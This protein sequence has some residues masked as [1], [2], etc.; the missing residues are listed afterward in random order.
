MLQSFSILFLLSV[1]LNYL[2]RKYLKLSSTIGL[3]I[4]GLIL[5]VSIGLLKPVFPG[6]Y[7]FFCN[8]VENT[9]FENLLFDGMLSF[10]LFAGAI[11]VNI[12][13]LNKEKWSVLL[14]ASLGVLISTFVVG[15]IVFF[16][17]QLFNIQLPFIYALLFG[18]LIS[19]TDPIAVIAILKE[20]GVSKSLEMKIEGESLFNDGVGV[21]V[22]SG[23]LLVL[24]AEHATAHEISTEI[25]ALF[26]EE[27]IGGIVYGLVLGFVGYYLINSVRDDH[28]LPVVLS[29]AIVMGGYSI[30]SLLGVSGPLAMVV[31]G[32]IIGN[33]F[34]L[35]TEKDTTHVVFNDIWEVIDEVLNGI[36]FL[37]LGISI[38]LIRF[39]SNQILLGV[40]A[41]FIVLIGRYISVV[42]P[43][44]FLKHQEG[45]KSDTL[46]VLTW[47]GLR[48]G[49]SLALA[50]SLPKEA[51]NSPSETLFVIT[52][53]VVLMSIILQG[54]TIGK[55]VNYLK[56]K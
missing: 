6:L 39:D 53:V 31:S 29:L 36:L 46:K 1:I 32:L 44:S 42:I 56:N 8:I 45:K 34:H 25:V 28:Q 13:D 35:N 52:Y 43:F 3:L 55:L 37:L 17:A 14:F 38:H 23:I 10:L 7:I 24:G 27:A 26:A 50:L 41:F 21:V 2:N 12:K 5:T 40:L 11:H 16:A 20:A 30:A 51:E 15:V 47:G 4:L 19:P 22:F 48:G 49:I 33:K 18:A 54:L 9:D